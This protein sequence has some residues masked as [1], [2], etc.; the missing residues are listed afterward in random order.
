MG[1][2]TNT[3]HS[4]EINMTALGEMTLEDAAKEAAGNW[5]SWTCFVWDRERDRNDPDNFA[6]FYT[7]NRDS[8]LL[9]QSNADAIGEAMEPFTDDDDLDVVMESHSHWAVGHVDG[10]SIRVYRNGEITEAFKAYHELSEQLADYPILNEEDYSNREY[11]AT[12]EN[13]NDAAWRVK[14]EYTLP[15]GW[16]SEVYTWL[17][18]HRSGSVENR[19]DQ[20]GYPAEDDLRAAFD[21]L[22]YERIEE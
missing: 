4:T 20:G 13:I 9:A 10:F 21:A 16:E 6:I 18:D 7:H 11:E 2:E 1:C 3:P 5:K 8:G 17:S 15:D 12:L 22:R 19:D 14:H